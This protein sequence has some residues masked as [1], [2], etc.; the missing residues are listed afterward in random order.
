M[1]KLLSLF[2]L[3]II[4]FISNAI[5]VEFVTFSAP[6]SDVRCSTKTAPNLAIDLVHRMQTRAKNCNRIFSCY[7]VSQNRN[8]LCERL[9]IIEDQWEYLPFFLARTSLNSFFLYP[10]FSC[11]RVL[12]TTCL[13]V[14]RI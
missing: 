1:I 8:I 14:L 3:P 13:V 9:L 11:K 4:I 7:F 10:F 5:K 6:F 12:R 2:A